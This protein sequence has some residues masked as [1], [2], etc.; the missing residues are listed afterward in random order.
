MYAFNPSNQEAEAGGSL[1]FK[2]SL[3]TEF[4]DSQGYTEK[5]YL[6]NKQTKTTTKKKQKEGNL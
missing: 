2:A 6:K 1:E 5:H 4:Q 3:S